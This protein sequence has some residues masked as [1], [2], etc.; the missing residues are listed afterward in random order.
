M[1]EESP[2]VVVKVNDGLYK[3][4]CYR[5]TPV[6]TSEGNKWNEPSLSTYEYEAVPEH[7]Q[8]FV[9]EIPDIKQLTVLD[10]TLSGIKHSS[11]VYN[12]VLVPMFR[13]LEIE[14]RY[15]ASET[16][17]SI[18]NYAKSHTENGTVIIL[19][20][21]TS[22]HEFVNGLKDS[23]GS[24]VNFLLVP[25]GTGNGVS[26]FLGHKSIAQAI[27]RFF[28]GSLIPFFSFRLDFPEGSVMES[29]SMPVGHLYSVVIS[30]CGY[31][32]EMIS[33]AESPEY[34][35]ISF[36]RY[37]KAAEKMLEIDHKYEGKLKFKS[38][39]ECHEFSDPYSAILYSNLS[40]V[41]MGS[42]MPYKD[43]FAK[44][45]LELIRQEYNTDSNQVREN[46]R[47]ALM[48]NHQYTDDTLSVFNIDMSDQIVS[49]VDF[50]DKHKWVVDGKIVKSGPG[51]VDIHKPN[52]TCN[53]WELF[54]IK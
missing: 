21:D 25:T 6:E 24:H 53:G 36:G 34:R 11:Y 47:M 10:S 31:H 30:G 40:V 23:P 38:H 17:N 26:T 29:T 12:R 13:E 52:T 18:E 19:S 33:L 8:E 44:K 2:I 15:V 27:S 35:E 43:Y 28:L 20:G 50:E 9:A 1:L 5:E 49:S 7:L 37:G 39:G 32:T 4:F 42:V 51:T 45:S 14:H 46:C 16:V 41:T 3:A 54:V 48:K 22:I